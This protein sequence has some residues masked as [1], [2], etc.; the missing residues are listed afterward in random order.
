MLANPLSSPLKEPH[1]MPMQ[2]LAQ[3]ISR[4][5]TDLDASAA[6]YYELSSSVVLSGDF[7]IEFKASTVGTPYAPFLGNK[8]NLDNYCDLNPANQPRIK[9]NGDICQAT[10]SVPTEVLDTFRFLRV[11]DVLNIST[12]SGITYTTHCSTE[13]FVFDFV[14]RRFGSTFISGF[15]S[16]IKAWSGGDRNTGDLIVDLPLDKK[17]PIDGI[18]QNRAAGNPGAPSHITAV[19]L[20]PSDSERYE[21]IDIGWIGEEIWPSDDQGVNIYG[22]ATYTDGVAHVTNNGTTELSG[23]YLTQAVSGS[24]YRFEHDVFD[25]ADAYGLF[26]IG[27]DAT[28][29]AISHAGEYSADIT[30]NGSS[31]EIKRRSGFSVDFKVRNISVKRLLRTAS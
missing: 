3:A 13:D 29:V 11:T 2:V 23:V 15:M 18:I 10:E 30:A 1:R 17:I 22:D 12:S 6:Q 16:G 31:I 4:Y 21:Q 14:G 7:E 20:L 28:G 5:F 24:E 19:N 8:L 9:I 26:K 25:F 27:T